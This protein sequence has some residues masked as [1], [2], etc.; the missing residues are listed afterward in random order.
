MAT[1]RRRSGRFGGFGGFPE[2]PTV[3]EI[4]GRSASAKARLQAGGG[5][6]SPVITGRKLRPGTFW[7]RAWCQN[8]ERYSDYEN[9]LPRGRTYVRRGAVIDLEI[10]AGQI[11]AT[12]AGSRATPY[13]IEIGIG[14]L[15]E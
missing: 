8:L 3:A 6:P 11:R 1:R 10:T 9:R 5:E 2:Q 13:D 4:E 12:V 7:G 15:P 14:A